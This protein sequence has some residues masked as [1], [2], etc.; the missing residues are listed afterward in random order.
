MSPED[1][2]AAAAA[3]ADEVIAR[4]PAERPVPPPLLWRHTVDEAVRLAVAGLCF[5]RG[6][7]EGTRS[8]SE[9]AFGETELKEERADLPWD[10]AADVVLGGLTV[11]GRIDRLDLRGDGAA[12]R[13]TDYKTG[14]LPRTAPAGALAHGADLQRV[15]Y[16]VAAMR[17]LS[18][19]RQVVSRLV[20]LR[21][22]P[23]A[24][25]LSGDLLDHTIREADRF[26]AAAAG[27]L[28]TGV[29]PVGP[30]AQEAYNDLRLALPAD[31]AGYSKRKR[32]A[33]EAAAGELLVLWGWT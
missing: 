22:G 27:L 25:T 9:V 24:R 4:W 16:A 11:G 19:V 26:V 28:L 31:L 1:I 12:A 2:E 32:K 13:V 7:M 33:V 29:A 3:A 14:A 17:R 20:Y 8:W 6:M 23:S 21:D 15:I 10:N 18:D 30:D 5:D